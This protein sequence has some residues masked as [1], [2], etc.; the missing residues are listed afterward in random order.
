M[1]KS[2]FTD[3]DPQWSQLRITSM[4]RIRIRIKV[5]RGILMRIHSILRHSG[6]CILLIC[7]VAVPARQWWLQRGPPSLRLQSYV[8]YIFKQ[9]LICLKSWATEPE[10][11]FWAPDRKQRPLPLIWLPFSNLLNK[12]PYTETIDL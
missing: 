6:T 4:S 8:T 10:P 5:K 12:G 9:K 11:C 3:L 2:Q 1:P 7:P